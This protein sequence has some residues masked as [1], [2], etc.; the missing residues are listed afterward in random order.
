MKLVEGGIS[1]VDVHEDL[2]DL[3]KDLRY[4]ASLIEKGE[5]NA[6]ACIWTGQNVDEKGI[7]HKDGTGV[8]WGCV[9]GNAYTLLGSVAQVQHEIHLSLTESLDEIED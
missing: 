4:I 2:R 6:V 3:A 8:T 1:S 7:K 9:G 5:V